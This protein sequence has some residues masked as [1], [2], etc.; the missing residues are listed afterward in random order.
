MHPSGPWSG[1][2]RGSGWSTHAWR[3]RVVRADTA[4]PV[5]FVAV[6]N[7]N[8]PPVTDPATD[9]TV[10]LVRIGHTGSTWA[11]NLSVQAPTH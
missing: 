9:F 10:A 2:E 3:G 11:Q 6:L 1:L 4:S 7:R 5:T 8:A